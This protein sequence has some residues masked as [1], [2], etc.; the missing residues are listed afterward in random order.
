MATPL[1]LQPDYFS[2]SGKISPA[3]P[4]NTSSEIARAAGAYVVEVNPE[5][6]PLSDLC[7]EVL[8]GKAGEILP[9]FETISHKKSQK[10]QD[11]F[12]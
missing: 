1:S 5:R 4:I 2:S 9:M 10:A 12:A 7:D 11:N 6:T 3:L 8:M